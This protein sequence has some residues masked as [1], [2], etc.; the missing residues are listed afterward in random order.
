M[1]GL[2]G[3]VGHRPSRDVLLQGL[4]RLEQR[5]DGHGTTTWI[6]GGRTHGIGAVGSLNGLGSTLEALRRG[7]GVASPAVVA[8][9]HPAIGVAHTHWATHAA[10]SEAQSQLN[11]AGSGRIRIALDGT[12]E[13]HIVFRQRAVGDTMQWSYETDAAA[14]AHLLALNYDGDLAEA[15]RC[16]LPDLDGCFAFLAICEEE[17]DTLVGV[18]QGRPLVVGVGEREHFI[19][20]SIGAFVEYTHDV[21]VLG[22]DQ[23]AEL[24]PDDLSVLD[25]AA[26]PHR[27]EV[28][29]V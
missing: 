9:D 13:N 23:I 29:T 26:R 20:S 8:T 17:P 24:R 27:P 19:A 28:S 15:V 12:I 7:P 25:G 22:D 11:G 3:Y 4:Q 21:A 18:R 10:F 5:D 2:I 1:C 6:G 14:V 16:S